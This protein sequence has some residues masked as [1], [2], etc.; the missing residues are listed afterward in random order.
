M[1]HPEAT[2]SVRGTIL[3]G[4]ELH[5]ERDG[6][7]LA[8]DGVIGAVVAP[9]R[10]QG[11]GI[12]QLDYGE[13]TVLPGPVDTH[14]HLTLPGDGRDVDRHLLGSSDE[15]LVDLGLAHARQALR[16]GVTTLR[17]LGAKG[18][19]GF[20]AVRRLAYGPEPTPRVISCGPVLTRP[21]GHGSTF[22][23]PIRGRREA[24][25]A[26]RRLARSGAGAIKVM[27]P[28][29]STPGTKAWRPALSPEELRAVVE[30]ARAWAFP[31]PRMSAIPRPRNAA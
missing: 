5:P 9:Q 10:A 13:W 2:F 26:V 19:T 31:W 3:R 4:D 16:G 25:D 15:E 28:G 27:A 6:C 30:E 20:E 14:C 29:G 21:E 8:S 22:G 12:P 1:S 18:Q 23:L 17:D 11:L 7:V 24:A